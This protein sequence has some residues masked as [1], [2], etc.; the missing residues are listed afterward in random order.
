MASFLRNYKRH[1]ATLARVCIA[2][3]ICTPWIISGSIL[4]TPLSGV[5]CAGFVFLAAL[6]IITPWKVKL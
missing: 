5:T 1:L 2:L 3:A 4:D 6:T